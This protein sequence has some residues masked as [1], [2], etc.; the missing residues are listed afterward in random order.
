MKIFFDDFGK[1]HLSECF[2]TPEKD[3]EVEEI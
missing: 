3:N 2:G 1:P